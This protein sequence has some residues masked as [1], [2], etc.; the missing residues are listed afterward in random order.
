[1]CK[2]A[3]EVPIGESQDKSRSSLRMVEITATRLVVVPCLVRKFL[4]NFYRLLVDVSFLSQRRR[5]QLER[6]RE[7]VS[8]LQIILYMK[9]RTGL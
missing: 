7:I 6:R 1:M 3:Q 8:L 4:E 5:R 9:N 2:T